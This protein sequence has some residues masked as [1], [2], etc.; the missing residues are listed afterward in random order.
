VKTRVAPASDQATASVPDATFQFP[1]G[2]SFGLG[3]AMIFAVFLF[4]AIRI[5]RGYERAVSRLGLQRPPKRRSRR[6]GSS[7]GLCSFCAASGNL[8][9]P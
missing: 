8:K 5:L 2:L 1:F 9:S 7:S 3:I 6:A 4:A